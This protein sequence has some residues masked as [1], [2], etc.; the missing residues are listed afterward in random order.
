MLDTRPNDFA[1]KAGA[2]VKAARLLSIALSQ[3][4]TLC[5]RTVEAVVGRY[6]EGDDRS[7]RWSRR[8]VADAVEIALAMTMV[9]QTPSN[10]AQLVEIATILAGRCPTASVRSEDQVRYQQFSSPAPLAAFAQAM[11]VIGPHDRVLEPSAG[12]GLLATEAVRRQVNLELNEIDPWRA[13]LLQSIWPTHPIT[14]HDAA[15]I[16]IRHKGVRPTVILMNPP[17]SRDA[18][19]RE[20]ALAGLRHLR[21]ALKLLQDGGR[22]IAIMPGWCETSARN[23]EL[24]AKAT[25]G[26]RITR[27][28]AIGRGG[29]AQHGT[30]V[31]TR[32]F[33]I[34][35]C[36]GPRGATIP[37]GALAEL[38]DHLDVPPREGL[39]TERRAGTISLFR[40][41]TKEQANRP[42]PAVAP[43]QP[44]VIREIDFEVL[45]TPAP[46]GEQIGQY[47]P[48][49]PSRVCFAEA[50]EHPSALVESVA[51]GS[52]AAPKPSYRPMLPERTITAKILSDA[53]LETI[54]YAGH[55]HQQWFKDEKGV[56]VRR[57]FYLGDGTGAGKG[58]QFA[59]IFLDN[60]LC[61]RR[62]HVWVSK[63]AALLEDARR[64]WQALGGVPADIR[65]IADWKLGS[66]ID[67]AEGVLFVPYGTLRS[68]RAE[69]NRLEQIIA[70]LG[71]EFE[72]VLG[73]DEAHSMG[74]VAG[75]EGAR[76]KTKGSDQGMA[77]VEL[78]ARLPKARVVYA[79]AT[80]ASD[81][82]NL[83]YAT[84]L[85]LWGPETAFPTR[86]NFISEIRQGG[87]AAMEVVARDLKALGLY[88]ARALSF[89][90]VEYEPVVHELTPDQIAVY[91]TYANAWS[92]VHQNMEDALVATN[93]VD[94][95]TG[96]TLNSG[97]K[98]AARSRF[99]NV[100]QRFFCQLL[101]SLKLPSVIAA[102]ENHLSE[103]MAVVVQL[104]STGEAMLDRRLA[105]R[106]EDDDWDIDLSPREYLADY[107]SR[108]FPIRAM[109]QYRD[110][111][112]RMRSRP[113]MDD[114]GQP[115]FSAEAIERRDALMEQLGAMPPIAP[116]LD[117]I[118]ERFGDDQVAEV[119]GRKRRLAIAKDGRQI[120][121]NRGVRSNLSETDA[122]MAGLKQILVFSDAGG[123]GR[124]Y[125]ASLEAKNQRR[126]AHL[127]LEPGWRADAAIQGL[128][129][130]NRTS[131]ASAPLFRPVT[132]DCR[133]ERRFI[134][135]IARR[136]DSLGALTRG[137]R[138]TGGQNLFDPAD[139]LESDYAKDA[140]TSWFNLLYQGKLKS[141]TFA[142]FQRRTGLELEGDEGGSLRDDL[143]PIQRWLNRILA[144][145]IA[146][147]NAIFD[148]FLGLVEH[149]VAKAREAGTLDIGV[150]TMMVESMQIVSDRVLRTDPGSGATTNLVELR[151]ERRR[152]VRQLSEML[153]RLDLDGAKAMRNE[154]SGHLAVIVPSRSELLDD[155][156]SRNRYA[157]MRV[158]STDYLTGEALAESSWAHISRAELKAGWAREVEVALAKLDEETLFIATGL[159]LPVWNKIPAKML[160]VVRIACRDG[161][162]LLGRVI[163]GTD[164]A[165][166]CQTMGIGSPTLTPSAILSAVRGRGTI[167]L[168]GLDRITVRQ[169]RVN[170]K[171]RIELIGAHPNRLSWYKERGCWTEIIQFKTRLFVAEERAEA[172]FASIA[173]SA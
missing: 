88:C 77:G 122:F 49:R 12:T 98:S 13:Q 20:D 142:D 48:Y 43:V 74:G 100:K 141:T 21:A 70:W 7:G 153:E 168:V 134:S 32:L 60:W 84:R 78:Q 165:R 65:P 3:G 37:I 79:S 57:S 9:E 160:S 89:A 33:V 144:L 123:T 47:L 126:R 164:V 36:N 87:I 75:G 148:E 170:G 115:V 68:G 113:M 140:L 101:L 114:N 80:G 31:A 171:P 71:D 119:T 162:S 104:V 90:G 38:V 133:G 96:E 103:G 29:F 64:D 1:A 132:T 30:D 125:H 99:E 136:L 76:G 54:V 50:G 95:L 86:E 25:A 146:V 4:E 2:L 62:K 53:Q 91:D 173:A 169:S 129:R 145:P 67:M 106:E 120:V 8:D 157:V 6:L 108:A 27:T 59:G 151:V 97:A 121:Q 150:E 10:T 94:G 161:R 11:A 52:V 23:A 172:L 24:F 18:F 111:E 93:V 135:T 19:G 73:F 40:G 107:L 152:R 56:L 110:E 83:A 105:D 39:G 137:Q 46:I 112:G 58:R 69:D 167:D 28:F 130:T 26:A 34:D 117:A 81:V 131:Q 155:G 16:D 42:M 45:E 163:D 147:Q 158:S 17:F 138:Q 139:N 85:G 14:R 154:K 149:R 51:M 143:P 63:N 156:T 109:E 118:I 22:L 159:L 55:A 102:I 41:L 5:Q 82:N 15:Q 92:I 127:L 66:L 61:G 128:G 72:G 166:L 124:S 35:K 116:A 44:L